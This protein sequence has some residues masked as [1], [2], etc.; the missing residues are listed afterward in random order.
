MRRPTERPMGCSR[1]LS[2]AT[3]SFASHT[4]PAIA[5]SATVTMAAIFMLRFAFCPARR[6]S[7]RVRTETPIAKR[8]RRSIGS[9]GAFPALRCACLWVRYLLVRG[10]LLVAKTVPEV[11]V[12]AKPRR[13][14]DQPVELVV[15]LVQDNLVEHLGW[16]QRPHTSSR[17]PFLFEKFG[18]PEEFSGHVDLDGHC[19]FR[20]QTI[21]DGIRGLAAFLH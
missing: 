9:E 18:Q 20:V 10:A 16:R 2:P 8:P 4:T 3:G 17:R 6:K 21:A 7:S 12:I 13:A 11:A 19:V 1:K 15:K 5:R 14:G